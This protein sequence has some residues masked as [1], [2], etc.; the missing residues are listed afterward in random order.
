MT[1]SR[2]RRA[3]GNPRRLRALRF[4]PAA[5]VGGAL[6]AAVVLFCFVGPLVYHS[7][8]I[9]ANIDVTNLPPGPGRPLGT[10]ANG[11]D[12]LGRLMVGGQSALEIGAA[13]AGIA[14]TFGVVWGVIAGF[15]GRFIDAIMMRIVDV[16]LALPAIFVLIYLASVAK[17]TIGLLIGVLAALS[18]LGPARLIRG[19]TLSLKTREYVA[20]AD[21]MGA[22]AG[23]II[24]RHLLP[25]TIG[26]IVVNLTFQA[27]DAI[28]ALATLSFLG[29][30][31]PSPAVNWGGMLSQGTAFLPDG[32]WWEVY[33][34]GGLIMITVVA[35]NFLGDALRDAL[36]GR[37][38]R[39]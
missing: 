14:T 18:W 16:V 38:E 12:I 31:L 1:T 32:Y 13:V 26:T 15:F 39:R 33:P 8:Q 6:I 25:N 7:D 28:I 20:A 11:Y 19:E 21:G 34:A 4:N 23:R 2:Y 36:D 5:V 27:A 37:L 9:T 10:D 29:F 22:R 24:L 30:G 17:P 3:G 35:F